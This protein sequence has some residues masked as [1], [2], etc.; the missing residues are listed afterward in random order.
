V[1]AGQKVGVKEVSDRIWLA[2][3]KDYDLGYFTTSRA[4]WRAPRTGSALKCYPCDWN[5]Q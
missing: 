5:G 3:F 2:S 1:I 4:D